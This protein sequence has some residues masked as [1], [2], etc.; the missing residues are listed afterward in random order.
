MQIKVLKEGKGDDVRALDGDHPVDASSVHSYLKR[1]FG[2]RLG[3][4]EKALK[5]K[6]FSVINARATC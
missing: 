5:V 6:N 4:A 1:A 3:D 2:P